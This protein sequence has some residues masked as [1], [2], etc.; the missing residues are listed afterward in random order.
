MSETWL[1]TNRRALALGMVVP[2]LM[3][4]AAL[5]GLAWSVMTGQHWAI[6][7]LMAVL[8]VGPLWMVGELLYALSRPRIG[9]E[10][11]ELLVYFDATRPTRVPIEIVEVFFLGQGPSELPPLKGRE[12]ETQNVIV[13]LAESATD[14][15]HRDVRPAIGHWC[16]G[17]I[18]I[19]GSW[20][21]RITPALMR[22]LN[23]RLAEIHRE[24]RAAE[25]SQREQ[26]QQQQLGQERRS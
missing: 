9:Y 10:P 3:L 16:E 20:C 14:W 23:H 17:Y 15:K 4:L 13:R 18:T 6:Q 26:G 5:G 22:E 1:K 24:R 2:G 25:K 19:R 8:T 7:V 11:G 21:E 12:P